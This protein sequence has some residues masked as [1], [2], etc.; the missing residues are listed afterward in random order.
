MTR[1]YLLYFSLLWSIICSCQIKSENKEEPT[2]KGATSELKNDIPPIPDIIVT[3]DHQKYSY[4]EMVD[5]LKLLQKAYPECVSFEMKG[6]TYQGRDIPIV[7]LGNKKASKKIMITAAI[8]AREYMTT[9]VVMSMLEYYAK[10]YNTESYDGEKY[11]DLFSD[12]CLVIMPM[13]NP[14]GVEIAQNGVKGAITKDVKDWVAAQITEG[15]KADQIKSNA[16]GID[17]NRNFSYGFGKD[18]RRVGKKGFDHYNGTEAYS[19]NET[20]LLKTVAEMHKYE[21]FLNYHT[22]GNLLY[23]G[24]D[25]SLKKENLNSEKLALFIQKVTGYVPHKESRA[26][27]SWADE[28]EHRFHCASVTIEMGSKNPVPLSEYNG[29]YKRNKLLWAKLLK[30]IHDKTLY[31]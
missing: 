21:F 30:A 7:Y 18:P 22:S 27:G 6:K 11:S 26:Y 16:R 12:V 23:H 20:R 10:S 29:I 9:L 19:E 31:Y 17:L 25:P 2:T 8:H 28:V 5:D 4:K 14:D 13:V 15:Q 1:F 24:S 3:T